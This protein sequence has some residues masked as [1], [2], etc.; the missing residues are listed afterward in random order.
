M[1]RKDDFEIT[2]WK[3]FL[4]FS[5]IGPFVGLV[6]PFLLAVYVLGFLLDVVGWYD[7]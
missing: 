5:L 7:T 4:S 1:F 3:D 6:M 2:S